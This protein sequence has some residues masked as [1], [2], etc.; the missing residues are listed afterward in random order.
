VDALSGF[1]MLVSM[2]IFFGYEVYRAFRSTWFLAGEYQK[3]QEDE[4]PGALLQAHARDR[5]LTFNKHAINLAKQQSI[6]SAIP[7]AVAVLLL[8]VGFCWYLVVL[9]CPAVRALWP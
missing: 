1:L 6:L 8:A 2:A 7:A 3:I 9:A 4:D 5:T